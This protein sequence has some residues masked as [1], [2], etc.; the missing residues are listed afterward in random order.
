MARWCNGECLR[1][2]EKI[3]EKTTVSVV[4]K[5]HEDS[6]QFCFGAAQLPS[7][8]TQQLKVGLR[9]VFCAK[10]PAVLADDFIKRFSLSTPTS[11]SRKT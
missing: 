6:R 7:R 11:T 9:E 4:I 3:R 8:V 10:S 1:A 5:Y 2:E